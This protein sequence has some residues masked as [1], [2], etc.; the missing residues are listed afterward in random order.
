MIQVVTAATGEDKFNETKEKKS[1]DTKQ[2]YRSWYYI[3][4]CNFF[5]YSFLWKVV[6]R[7]GLWIFH[8]LVNII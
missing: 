2:L 6:A 4:A 3:P 7:L 5:F 1:T 8:M